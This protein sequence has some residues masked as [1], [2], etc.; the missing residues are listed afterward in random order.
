MQITTGEQMS[1]TTKEEMYEELKVTEEQAKEAIELRECVVRLYDNPDF[2]KLILE[3]LF[4]NEAKRLV[5][6]KADNSVRQNNV[7]LKAIEDR[8]T[9]IGEL[10]QYFHNTIARG[11]QMENALQ[12]AKEDIENFEGEV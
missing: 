6:L 4:T 8:I 10:N 2:K 7:V 12:Q 1:N 9:T 3:D 5:F 11:H